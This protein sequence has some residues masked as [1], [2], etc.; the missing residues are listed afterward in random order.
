MDIGELVLNN[1]REFIFNPYTEKQV[2][3][4]TKRSLKEKLGRKYK[5]QKTCRCS[6]LALETE[7]QYRTIPGLNKQNSKP[8]SGSIQ[9]MK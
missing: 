5:S 8:L 3:L 6:K 2:A 7:K 9:A 4:L 1:E